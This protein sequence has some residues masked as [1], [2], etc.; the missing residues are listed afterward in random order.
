[1][2]FIFIAAAA[3]PRFF[4]LARI[5][6]AG[7]ASALVL[8][9]VLAAG[10]VDVGAV[11]AAATL[12]C[13]HFFRLVIVLV[14]CIGGR[15]LV[16]F[17]VGPKN[18]CPICC[19]TSSSDCAIDRVNRWAVS[20]LCTLRTEWVIVGNVVCTLGTDGV[21]LSGVANDL[22]MAGCW[23]MAWSVSSTSCRISSAPLGL[24]MSLIAFAQSVI[25][26][27]TLSA[28]VMVGLVILL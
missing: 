9:L 21:L 3:L 23:W 18:A 4:V 6:V 20:V 7:G 24:V 15:A 1:V 17:S 8:D 2:L 26:F 19:L 11:C 22:M 27:M 10:M 28:W 16:G 14:L 12:C 5:L 25:A 13:L